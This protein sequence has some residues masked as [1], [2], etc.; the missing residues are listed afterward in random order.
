MIKN[1]G[2]KSVFRGNGIFLIKLAPF[3]AFEF[4]FYEFYKNNLFQV[5]SRSD[6]TYLE[7]FFSGGLAGMTGVFIVYPLD[8]IKTHLTINT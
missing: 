8:V 5:E 3:S 7:K 1:E 4:F 6:L 2:L